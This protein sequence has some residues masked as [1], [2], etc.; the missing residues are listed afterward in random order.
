MIDTFC[1]ANSP[2]AFAFE[3][4]GWSAQRWDWKFG[5]ATDDLSTDNNQKIYKQQME[6]AQFLGVA[7]DCPTKTRDQALQLKVPKKDCS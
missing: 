1:G 3:L 7:L 2:L 6:R 4:C 5:K